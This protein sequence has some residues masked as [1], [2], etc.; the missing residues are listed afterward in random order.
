M[1]KLSTIS[2]CSKYKISKLLK[3]KIVIFLVTLTLIPY[4]VFSANVTVPYLEL[5]TRGTVQNGLYQLT[6]KGEMDLVVEGG[7]KFGGKLIL[8]Y[9]SDNLETNSLT[10]SLTFK[11]ASVSIKKLLSLPLN[12]S[13]FVGENDTFCSGSDFTNIF[14]SIPITS[15]Y[16]GY[17]YFPEG[18]IYDGIYTISGTGLKLKLTPTNNSLYALYLYQDSN[19]VHTV[20]NEQ[21][22][23][24][25]HYSGDF[26]FML[27]TEH[28][29][30][31]AF[32][33]M[34]FPISSYGYYR[35]GLLF[36]TADQGVE[37]LAQVGIP[38]WDPA[39]DL[40]GINLFYLLFEPRV[41]MGFFSIIPTFFWHPE[42]Y[43]QKETGELGSFDVNVNFLFGNPIQS[44]ISGGVE[45]NLS[46]STIG[47]QQFLV[48]LS[49]YIGFITQGVMW[50]LKIN[51]RLWP[52]SLTNFVESFIGIRAEF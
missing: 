44:P 9:N 13:Y 52:F 19:I 50:K 41:H 29:K 6:T 35:G 1:R 28:I 3:V 17:I 48:K 46:F 4:R 33:G 23:W 36:Y 24:L 20:N 25:G 45:S 30:F 31:E 14:G 12:F 38:R 7:Y 16:S 15:Q 47:S 21:T 22:V 34:T 43:N 26:R 51:F 10:D 40:F 39:T 11:G 49:P 8:S 27:N 32:A 42:Y 37:F 18:I 5:I 2:K